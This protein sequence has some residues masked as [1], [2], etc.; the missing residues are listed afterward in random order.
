M[1]CPQKVAPSP[2]PAEQLQNCISGVETRQSAAERP[3]ERPL[4]RPTAGHVPLREN[5]ASV[6]TA[7]SIPS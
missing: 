1:F 2:A 7:H 4:T 5:R 3:N 6:L